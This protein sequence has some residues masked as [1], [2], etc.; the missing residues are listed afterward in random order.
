MLA[1]S[2]S[3]MGFKVVALGS[4]PSCP[5]STH[6]HRLI[7]G[8]PLDAH[9]ILE[10]G[11][12][13]DVVTVE[14]ENVSTEAL[15]ELSLH[16]PVHPSPDVLELMNDKLRQ[17]QFLR[18]MGFPIPDFEYLPLEV[19]RTL[20]PPFVQKARRGGYDG[21]GVVIV[22]RRED[23]ANLLTVD[24]YV[25]EFVT[26]EKELAVLVARSA[27]GQIKTFPPVEM[28]FEA[29]ANVLSYLLAPARI[30]STVQGEI[31]ELSR[32]L[33]ENLKYVGV[34]AV[35]L[36]LSTNGRVYVN[37][38]APRVHNSGHHTIEA[39]VTSQFEQHIRAITGL[40]LGE[41]EQKYPAAMVNL[42][43]E[44]GYRGSPLFIG[45]SEVLEVPGVSVHIYGKDEVRPFRKMGHVTIVGH[46]H[47]E[48]IEKAEF[49]RR[50]LKVLGE[51]RC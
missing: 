47:E 43:G 26:I 28:V 23:T 44:P 33:V 49:V 39:C 41:T 31:L 27:R 10:L 37:E 5:I 51:Q 19:Q 13:S 24:S 18:S 50:K 15:K 9:S 2:A 29:R 11:N 35:E 22:R 48:V 4:S 20:Q 1:F 40:P 30:D 34:L 32:E 7:V 8:S 12:V 16:R 42:L 25:E 45:L 14:I 17:R 6:V 46:S 3:K 21:R 36:F 38:L